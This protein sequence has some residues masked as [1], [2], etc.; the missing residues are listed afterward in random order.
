MLNDGAV[1]RNENT[2]REEIQLNRSFAS[3]SKSSCVFF[4]QICITIG[5]FP[6]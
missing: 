5:G 1:M 4:F 2:D 3:A 6:K